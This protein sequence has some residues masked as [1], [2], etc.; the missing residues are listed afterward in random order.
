MAA[1]EER[2]TELC[3][4]LWMTQ[5]RMLLTFGLAIA[6]MIATMV[7]G[8]KPLARQIRPPTMEPKGKYPV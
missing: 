3:P 7:A 4:Q 2:A 6:A 5:H 8:A 1:F